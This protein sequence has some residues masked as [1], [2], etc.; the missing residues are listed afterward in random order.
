[1]P[2]PMLQAL[3]VTMLAWGW[4]RLALTSL[5]GFF[6]MLRPIE[7][8]QLSKNSF[9]TPIDHGLGKVLLILL[10]STKSRTRGPKQQYVRLDEPMVIDFVKRLLPKLLP[11]ERIWPGSMSQ[12]R[13][14]WHLVVGHLTTLPKLVYPSSLRPGGASY[15]FQ[16]WGEDLPRLQWRGRWVHQRTLSHYIQEL[17]AVHVLTQVPM[18]QRVRLQQLALMFPS[19]VNEFLVTPSDESLLWGWL[20]HAA[21]GQVRDGLQRV[22]RTEA[23]R[24]APPYPPTQQ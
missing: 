2:W 9:V 7:L 23:G 12:F 19:V 15:L 18:A 5:L 14:H 1:M 16:L 11:S 6:A 17:G 20:L 4:W 3:V 10:P 8:L 24:Y 22:T 21:R 13:R